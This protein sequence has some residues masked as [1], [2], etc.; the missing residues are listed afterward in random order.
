MVVG[1]ISTGN[2]P[3][4]L[5]VLLM[6]ID[7]AGTVV[8][9][10]TYPEGRQG[11][12]SAIL[13]LDDGGFLVAG[14]TLSDD[15]DDADILSLW[16]DADGN[17]LRSRKYGTPLN[18]DGRALVRTA[19][20]GYVILGISVDPDDF[21]ADAGAAGYSGFDG[22]SNAYV[23]KVDA[24]GKEI[25]SR[26]YTTTDN[27]I[28]SGGASAPDGGVVVL[29]YRLGYPVDDNDILL[30]KLDSDGNEVW[31]RAW[32]DGD[33]SGYGLVATRDGGYAISGML[34]DPDDPALKKGDALLIKVDADG[35]EIWSRSYGESSMIETA[36]VVIET[37]AGH[38]VC[39][40][41]QEVSFDDYGDDLCI[42]VFDGDGTPLSM[43]VTPTSAHNMYEGLLE[44]PDG[45][46][47]VT[48]SAAQ[49]GRV[50]R[51]QLIKTSAPG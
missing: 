1:E 43:S 17:E 18:E 44:C 24:E 19:D 3:A 36:H 11:A 4:D 25:W 33:A 20:G 38:F 12:G 49:A 35:N 21:V 27:V 26:R 9:E 23:L 34:A 48:G 15:G 50:F 42:A 28:V 2:Q 8:W 46:L 39:V 14:T 7:A 10:K 5:R 47:I 37:A 22:R 45:T 13:A 51:I 6:K 31:S 41:W 30:A 29:T 40:G 32:T 16:L